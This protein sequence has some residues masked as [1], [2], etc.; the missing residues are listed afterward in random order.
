MYASLPNCNILDKNTWRYY[1]I[2][3]IKQAIS[4][5]LYY[6]IAAATDVPNDY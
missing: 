1:S 3:L 6:W 5:N 4:E 2:S